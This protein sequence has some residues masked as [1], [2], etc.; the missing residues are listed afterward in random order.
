VGVTDSRGPDAEVVRVGVGVLVRVGVAEGRRVLALA[1]GRGAAADALAV[2]EEDA[3]GLAPAA[4]G[5]AVGEAL[6]EAVAVAV[7][8]PAGAVD[9]VDAVLPSVGALAELPV[10]ELPAVVAVVLPHAA[11]SRAPSAARAAAGLVMWW[12]PK[13][14]LA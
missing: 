1:L 11:R 6:G 7:P 14:R 8:V 3:D 2:G 12:C 5:M 4:L 13:V 10:A 9:G